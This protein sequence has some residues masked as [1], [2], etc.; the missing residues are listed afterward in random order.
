MTAGAPQP[1][2]EVP[3][4]M[5]VVV[6]RDRAAEAGHIEVCEAAAAAAVALLADDRAAQPGG[7]WARAVAQWRGLAIRKVVRRADGKRWADVQELPGVTAAIPPVP[8]EQDSTA[9]QPEPRDPAERDRAEGD[10]SARPAAAVRAFVPAPVSPLPKALAKLQVG[11]TNFPA[12]G[13]STAPDAVVTVGIRPGLGMTTG[14]AA[15]QC[16]HAAQRAWET[17]PEAARRRWQEAGFRT[18]VVDLDAAAWEREWPVRITD[19]GF[20]ELDGPTQTTVAGWTLDGGSA[21][22]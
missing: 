1:G 10:Q 14:K 8:G 13:P 20:T 17:M 2:P 4:A 19:A 21:P 15:A 12:R 16:A 9:P 22:V 3:W 11:E 6:F 18:R 5:Q 7:E